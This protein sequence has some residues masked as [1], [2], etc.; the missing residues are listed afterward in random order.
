MALNPSAQEHSSIQSTGDVMQKRNPTSSAK[1]GGIPRPPDAVF[2]RQ[3]A[4]A[5][6]S[7]TRIVALETQVLCRG[8]SVVRALVFRSWGI[9]LFRFRG[10][11]C[12][13]ITLV[14]FQ[15]LGGVIMGGAA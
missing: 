11:T 5:E 7:R 3:P 14:A 1:R 8:K 15:L 12:L 9:T 2:P 13:P 6:V 4:V 10:G